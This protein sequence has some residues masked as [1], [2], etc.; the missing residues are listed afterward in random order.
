MLLEISFGIPGPVLLLLGAFYLHVTAAKFDPKME[1]DVRNWIG[2]VTGE[3]LQ[4]EELSAPPGS[5]VIMHTHAAH[6]VSPREEGSGTRYCVVTAY[7]NPGAVSQSRWITEE[8]A[9]KTTPGLTEPAGSL[10]RLW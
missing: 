3:P 7:R 6:G 2:A 9:Q 10:K 5:V 4:V 8:F 1:A